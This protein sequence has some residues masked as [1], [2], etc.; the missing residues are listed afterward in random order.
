MS[1]SYTH[2]DVYKR[3]MQQGMLLVS[4]V[5]NVLSILFK[6]MIDGKSYT[7]N[8]LAKPF[9]YYKWHIDDMFQCLSLIHI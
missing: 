8:Q 5:S 1:V 7:K 2:L 4:D 3:Q 6:E 9:S